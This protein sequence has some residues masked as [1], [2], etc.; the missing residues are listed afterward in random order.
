MKKYTNQSTGPRGSL[1]PQLFKYIDMSGISQATAQFVDYMNR[2]GQTFHINVDHN[3]PISTVKCKELSGDNLFGQPV[4]LQYIDSGMN[5]SVYDMHI[6]DQRFALKINR[7]IY[8]DTSELETMHFQNQARNLLNKIYIG[9]TFEFGGQVYS[10]LLMDF[11]PDSDRD[12]FDRTH[13]RLFYANLTKGLVYE[14]WSEDNLKNGKVID[15]GGLWK[16]PLPLTRVEVD[17]MKKMV[18]AMRTDNMPAFEKM[19]AGAISAH[20]MVIDYMMDA[21]MRM[22]GNKTPA[23]F[24]KFRVVITDKYNIIKKTGR[25]GR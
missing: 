18:H 6:G 12:S 8:S 7:S 16:R 20:P 5:G 15:R 9:S 25:A 14:D 22:L 17:F 23:R 3:S 11:V 21:M 10:W 1:P 19:A 4:T 13:E 24:R 2:L